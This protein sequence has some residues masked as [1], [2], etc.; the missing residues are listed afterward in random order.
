MIICP[1]D[2][3]AVGVCGLVGAGI[4][5]YTFVFGIFF[6]LWGVGDVYWEVLC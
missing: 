1:S 3:A 6:I 4:S 2:D 5:V